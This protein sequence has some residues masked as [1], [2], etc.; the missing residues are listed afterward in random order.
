MAFKTKIGLSKLIPSNLAK[1]RVSAF[2]MALCGAVISGC[3]LGPDFTEPAS[4]DVK[5]YTDS[6][7]AKQFTTV[8]TASGAAQS[9]VLG[10]DIQ[11]QWWTL[12]RSPALNQLIAKALQRSPDLQA[13]L[14]ALTQAQEVASAKQYALFPALDA[15]FSNSHQKISGAQFGNPNFPGSVYSLSNAS[16]GVTYTLDVFGAIRRQIE[17]F[18][19]QASYQEFQLEGAF[20]MLAANVATTAIQEASLK[21]QIA[22]TFDI[23]KAQEQELALVQQQFALGGASKVDVLALQSQLQQTRIAIPPLQLQLAQN[24]HRLTAL[25]GELPSTGLS[26]QFDLASLQLPLQLP[27]SLPSKLVQQRPDVQAQVALLHRASA[28]IGVV[29]AQLFPD[30]TIKAN[31]GSIATQIGDLFVPGSAIWNVGGNLLQPVF[32]GGELLHKRRAALAA[33]EQAAAQYRST[34]LLAF[35]NV[36]DTLSALEFDA[37]EL[38]AQDAAVLAAQ[39]SLE[40]SRNQYQNGAISSL[41]V[42]NAERDYQQARIGQ[43]TAQARRL[44]DTAALFQALGGGWWNRPKLAKTLQ[45]T[46]MQQPKKYDCIFCLEP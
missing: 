16:V 38:Q 5:G 45:S 13:A 42:L 46:Q 17:G 33:Y 24:R 30:F 34:V 39:E 7:Q 9:I 40:L 26:A 29:S 44:A 8:A 20:L 11:G 6:K 4:P 25:V 22:A 35:Q 36:A 19:A 27:L 12:F 10:K 41:P 37:A 28:E 18:E 1:L 43:I 31:V 23:I 21:A 32:H 2:G 15:S 3:A 14:S